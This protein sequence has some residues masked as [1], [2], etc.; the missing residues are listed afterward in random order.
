MTRPPSLRREIILW[1]SLVLLLALTLFSALAYLIL[2]Q[3]L[4][5]TG[6]ASLRQTAAAAEQ[7][8]APQEIPR[9]EVREDRLEP[10]PD[11]VEALRRRTLLG[12]GEVIEIY[13]A[14]SGNVEGRAL[15]SFVLISLL[16]IPLTAIGAAL[17]GRVIVDRLL[18][19][20]DQL[21]TA[22]RQVEIGALSRRVEEPERSAELQELAQAFNGM[23]TRLE[24]AVDTLRR[25]TAD[26]SHELRTPLTAIRGTAQLALTRERSAAELQETLAEILEETEWM[27]QMVEG[28]L[29]L[30]RSEEEGRAAAAV[31]LVELGPILRDVAELGGA[32]AAGKPVKVR[33][34]VGEPLRVPG[35]PAALRQIFLNLVSNAVKFTDEG[36]VTLRARALPPSPDR[37]DGGSIAVEVSDTGRGMTREE[38]SRVFDRFYR[39][40][41]ARQRSTGTGLGLPI[42]R[43]MTERLGGVIEVESEP[44]RGSTFRVVLPAAERALPEGTRRTDGGSEIA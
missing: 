44:G 22:T 30:A 11:Q 5:R 21:V 7:L 34:K 31:H 41:A 40:D 42:A 14:R 19:P 33:T 10:G 3:T 16:L 12:T 18:R 26:A 39:G 15:R 32:L 1:F 2:Q 36:S 24:G 20:L 13:V 29:T 28:L 43:L 25:F 8:I 35:E 23:L 9:V 27:L 17:G 37:H 4:S 6:T 38:M